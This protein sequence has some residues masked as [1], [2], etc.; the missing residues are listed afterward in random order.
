MPRTKGSAWAYEYK[1]PSGMPASGRPALGDDLALTR[2]EPGNLRALKHGAFSPRLVDPRAEEIAAEVAE[3]DAS[4][5][6][7]SVGLFASA[8]AR[9]ELVRKHLATLEVGSDQWLKESAHLASLEDAA[10]RHGERI[11]QDPVSRARRIREDAAAVEAQR[12]IQS[13]LDEG[14]EIRRARGLEVDDD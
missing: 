3:V 7:S 10:A 1:P 12:D 9:A 14:A 4:A 6:P 11:G 13:L 2:A 8:H 5:S